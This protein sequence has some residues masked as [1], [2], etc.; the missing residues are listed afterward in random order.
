MNEV[1]P[2][3][4]IAGQFPDLPSGARRVN[5]VADQQD[6]VLGL[7]HQ[8]G[9]LADLPRARPVVDK[10]IR[11]GRQGI[12]DTQLFEDHMGRKLDVSRTG[13]RRHRAPNRLP[14]DFVGLIGI[15]DRRAVLHRRREK[16]F[17]ADELDASTPDASFG[18]AG[19]LA[20]E[21]DDRRVL[22]LGAH[23][24][25]GDIGHAGTQRADAQPRL[26][27]HPRDSLG[28]ETRTLFVVR[29]DHRPATRFRLQ[30][31]VHEV[32]VR[33][34]EQRIHTLGL[35]QVEN[36]LVNGH[37]HGRELLQQR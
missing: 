26:A 24:R 20:T 1:P 16:C 33:D 17:L 35:E 11:A 10:T 19:P 25:T 13:C 7:A 12:G 14:N 37:S 23:H 30:E 4:W 3:V 5:A 9:G 32:R 6:R 18:D 31:H 2:E 29:R 15:F 34:A 22:H 8:P 28:H 36:A 21:E 27:G